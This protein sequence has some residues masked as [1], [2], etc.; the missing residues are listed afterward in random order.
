MKT[1]KTQKAVLLA[2]ALKADAT[3]KYPTEIEIAQVGSWRTP[4]HG[5]FELTVNDFNE[6]VTHFDAGIYRVNGTE[7]LPG[8]LDHLG[9]DTPAAFR[10]NSVYVV[11]NKFMASVTWTALGKEKLDRDEYRYISF[12]FNTRAQPFVNPEN[13]DEVLVNVLTGATLTNDPLFKKLKPVMASAR[14]GSNKDEGEDMDL[15]TIRA[16]KLEDLSAEEKAFLEENKAE[17]TAEE[18]TAFG[19]EVEE[20]ETAE[21]KTAREAKE[22]QDAIDAQKVIDDQPAADALAAD[23]ATK[24]EASTKGM[25]KDQ[26]AMFTKLQ[27]SVSALEADA[28]AGR[29]A[30]QELLK[31]RLTASVSA[32]VARGAIKSDQL[33][34]G[35]ELL[36]ASTEANRTKLTSFLEALPSNPLMASAEGSGKEEEEEVELTKEEIEQAE[37]FGNDLETVKAYKKEQL[38]AAAKK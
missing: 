30:Q 5:N 8:T 34:A 12:E 33:D 25:S 32:Q 7:P 28:K 15:K 24:L 17:L 21:A 4:W 10:I 3:G 16:K 13:E 23:E 26:K 22:A 20:V 38:K 2:H 19:L 31:T 29:E 6:A 18:L 1:T 14:S 35:V 9:G 27:A 36:L 11:D 37:Q